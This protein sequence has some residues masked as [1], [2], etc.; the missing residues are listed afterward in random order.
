MQRGSMRVS[1]QGL[2]K[3]LTSDEFRLWA[4]PINIQELSH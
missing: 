2:R 1:D 4:E 3:A